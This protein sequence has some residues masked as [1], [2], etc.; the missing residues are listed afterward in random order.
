MN[1]HRS[2]STGIELVVCSIEMDMN[3]VTVRGSTSQTAHDDTKEFI[4]GLEMSA[5]RVRP[6]L[7]ILE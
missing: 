2:R 7:S 3:V 4:R 6:C 5:R 1:W